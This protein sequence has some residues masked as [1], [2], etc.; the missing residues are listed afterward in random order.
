LTR[1]ESSA[2]SFSSLESI[3]IPRN[4]EIL[5]SLCFN[6]CQ[7]LSSI[8][9]ESNSRLTRIESSAF[10]F[11]SLESIEIPRNVEILGSSCFYECESLS[12]ISFES[13]SRLLRMESEAFRRSSLK[14]IEIP[15]NVEILGSSCFSDCESLSSISFE[16][17]SQ[18]KRIEN[19]ALNGLRF[20]AFLPPSVLYIACDAS[21]SAKQISIVDV[22]SCFGYR[23]WRI[24]HEVGIQIDFR[25]IRRFA[26]SFLSLSDS[27]FDLLGLNECSRLNEIEPISTQIYHGCYDGLEIIVKSDNQCLGAEKC[28]IEKR[29]EEFMNFRH[30]CIAGVIGVI[31]PSQLHGLRIVRQYIIGD[32]LSKV[33]STSPEWWTPTAKAKAVVGLAFGLRF[34]HSLGLVHGHLTGSNVVFTDEGMIQITDFYMTGLRCLEI[35][36]GSDSE[37]RDIFA[38]V[39]RH[40][41]DARAF[42]RI[43]SEIVGISS[44]PSFVCELIKLGQSADS[45]E[46]MPFPEV[47]KI[48]KKN[49]FRILEGVNIEEVANFVNWIEWSEKLID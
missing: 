42:L 48:L 12:S 38:N 11:S 19:Y 9:F 32:P 34:A 28:D 24:V 25:R 43:L 3:E 17:D 8:S 21:S 33:V 26:S 45:E 46:I 23:Q 13:N 2:F 20:V 14:S 15:R 27:L 4:V 36:A 5:G 44:K 16:S 7:S 1:I 41:E 22:D 29:T 31:L 47:L 40:R 18:L 35:N 6:G 10:S 30:P 39:L 49:K 37:T